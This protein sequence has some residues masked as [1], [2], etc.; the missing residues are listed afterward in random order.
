M[1]GGVNRPGVRTVMGLVVLNLSGLYWR[2]GRIWADS[3]DGDLGKK[4]DIPPP[5]YISGNI[6]VPS[7]HKCTHQ[8]AANIHVSM[9][10]SIHPYPSSALSRI[11]PKRIHLLQGHKQTSLP[12][13]V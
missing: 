7:V 11:P 6:T 1:H 3:G 9:C 10:L 5:K 12:N 8:H 2:L 13:P 4:S